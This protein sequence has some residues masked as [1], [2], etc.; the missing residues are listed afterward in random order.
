MNGLAAI[1]EKVI[2]G[3]R[4][5]FD[6]GVALFHSTEL[7]R[8]G[9]LADLVRRRKH[10]EPVATYVIGRN[11]NYTNV[12]WVRCKFCAF[13]RPPGA[14]DGYVLSRDEIFHKIDELVAAGGREVFLQGGL[15]PKLRIEYYEEL[16]SEIK[17]RYAV[18]L[19]S[20]SPAE[21][22]YIAHLANLS[23]EEAIVRLRRAGLDTIPGAG[24]EILVDEVRRSVAPFRDAAADWLAVMRAAH[25]L[26]MRTTAT[27]TFGLGEKVE[28]RVEH[29]LKLRALQDE[30]GGFTSFTTWNF[31]PEGT[32]LGGTRAGAFDYL[33]TQAI[34]RLMLD[35]FDNIQVSWLTQGAKIGQLALKYGANDFGSTIFEENVIT[36]A[37]AKTIFS[38]D[39]MKRLISDAGY[40]PRLRD[41]LYRILD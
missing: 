31:Q 13:Y 15:N 41:T 10:P 17:A 14:E 5:S 16:F 18:H 33:R 40:R 28:H 2:A 37:G 25:R 34:A 11:I 6:D 12:C 1:E 20:L 3:E 4:L 7:T 30:T 27:M 22:I 39:E 23:I 19:H 24:A 8:I 29:L 35:N 36:A 32:E 26:G 21:I 9:M 38:I